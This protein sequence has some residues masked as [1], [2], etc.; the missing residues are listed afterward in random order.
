MKACPDITESQYATTVLINSNQ[1]TLVLSPQ[2]PIFRLHYAHKK[3]GSQ[4]TTF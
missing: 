1:T 4:N 2:T 3:S